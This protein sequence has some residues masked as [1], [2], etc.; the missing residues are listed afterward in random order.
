[1]DNA[2]NCD[3]LRHNPIDIIF[4]LP[5]YGIKSERNSTD[6]IDTKQSVYFSNKYPSLCK[7]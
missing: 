5:H 1:M 6:E 7:I 2:H 4:N 3:V